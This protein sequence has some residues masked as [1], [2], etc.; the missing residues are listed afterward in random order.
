MS[1]ANRKARRRRRQHQRNGRRRR[2]AFSAVSL[3]LAAGVAFLL[4]EHG[5]H[6]DTATP[7]FSMVAYQG[8]HALGGRRVTFASLVG[9]GTPLVLNF[10]AARCPAC[11]A[12]MPGFQRIHRD[13]K[14]HVL[15]LGVDVG[16]YTGLGTHA[17]ARAFLHDHTIT[18]PAAYA[19]TPAPVRRYHVRGMPTTV[20]FDAKGN[21]V[22]EHTGYFAESQL[23]RALTKLQAD[24]TGNMP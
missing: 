7:D 18:Y 2:I 13:L 22:L 16:T 3:I 1:K 6:P 4:L 20:I 17:Q 14:Q 11:Q 12:E 23:R 10:W 8:Q 15:I 24:A 9:K 21:R 5:N 19:T